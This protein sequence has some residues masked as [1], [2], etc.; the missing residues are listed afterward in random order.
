MV[1]V[2]FVSLGNICRSPAGEGVLKHLAAQDPLLKN[3]VIQ[4]CGMGDW[5]IGHFPDERIQTAA[6]ARGIHLNSRAQQY[7]SEF[8]DEYD[9]IL[10]ADHEV[11]NDLY[12]HAQTPE[13]TSK[14]HLMT[15][16]STLYKDQEIGDPYY[17]GASAFELTLD[18]LEDSCNGLI[19]HIK[20]N[21]K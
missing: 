11:L 2:L 4:S 13:Q 7:R 9:C 3:L 8:L 19:A 21:T 5:H 20:A 17:A 12:R 6:G 14:I 18:M 16:Y 1:K 15:H 10:A